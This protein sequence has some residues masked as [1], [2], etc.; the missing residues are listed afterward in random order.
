MYNTLYI[1][2]FLSSLFHVQVHDVRLRHGGI[3]L[4]VL[5]WKA[6]QLLQFILGEHE[7]HGLAD[8]GQRGHEEREHHGC[9]LDSFQPIQN[10]KTDDLDDGVQVHSTDGQ[11]LDVVVL[12]VLGRVPDEPQLQPVE[13][14]VAGQAR[15]SHVEKH[16]LQHG[17]RQELQH[18]CQ[19]EC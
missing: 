5:T 11:L 18:W 12:R 1:L 14:V 2:P 3:L 10:A 15:N 4:L 17:P 16:A 8:D 19:E 9:F 13:E 7:P 6:V